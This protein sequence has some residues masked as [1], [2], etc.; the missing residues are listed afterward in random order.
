MVIGELNLATI[1]ESRQSG[2]VLPL[3][4][5]QHT[6]EVTRSLEEIKL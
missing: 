1:R 3:R 5:S 6:S 2:T 4:D